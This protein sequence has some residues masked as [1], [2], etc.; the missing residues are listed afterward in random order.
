VPRTIIGELGVKERSGQSAREALLEHLGERSVLLVLDNFEH[1]LPA[2]GLCR[3]LLTAAPNVQL[4]VTSR[5]PLGVPEEHVYRVP[6]LELPDRAG[7][8]SIARLRRTEAL[9]L[10]VD[11]AR[12]VR[13]DFE[14]SETNAESVV[15]LCVR[16][17]GLPLALELAAARCDLLSPRALLERL[18]SRL[19]LLRAAPGSGLTERHWTLRG[20]IEWSY[21]LLDPAER[22]LFTSLGVFV[23]GFT[24]RGAERVAGQPDL[25]VL[26]GI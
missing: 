21:E 22:Q 7:R 10:F 5:A 23:G 18:D 13:P 9:R 20:A 2:L 3:E 25:D 17:D 26:E 8:A 1:V 11:R 14:L 15:E 6:P 4:L 19:D 16:L 12:A 24:L